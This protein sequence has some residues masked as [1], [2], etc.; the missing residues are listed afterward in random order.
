[1][2][3]EDTT[4]IF[5]IQKCELSCHP[6]RSRCR[7]RGSPT[8]KYHEFCYIAVLGVSCGLIFAFAIGA[9]DV[10]NAFGSSV[11]ARSLKLWQAI[12]LGSIMELAGALL[13]GA[14]ITGTIRGKIIRPEFY[15]DEPEVFMFGSLCALMVG[16]IWLLIATAKEFPVSTTHGIVA[17]Y[18][19]F[20]IR[21]SRFRFRRLENMWQDLHRLVCYT[22]FFWYHCRFV[23]HV[24]TR[25]GPQEQRQH[26]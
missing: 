13:L 20:S 1:M 3:P 19:D 7:K 14:N 21:Y 17:A 10:A 2:L 22:H 8:F 11:S 23:F 25:V 26:L 18:L 15:E 6:I 24:A 5:E 16:M 9:N 4:C 12:I